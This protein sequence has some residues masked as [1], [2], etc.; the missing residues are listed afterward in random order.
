MSSP[1][2][3]EP[4]ASAP[5]SKSERAYRW[6]RDRIDHHRYGPGYRLVLGAI[7]DELQM[8]VV[9]V[10]EA[11]RRLEAE[12]LVTFERNVGARVAVVD[13]QEYVDTMQTLGIVEGTATAM[14]A[15]LLSPGDLRQADLINRQMH[16]LLKSFDAQAFTALNQQFHSILFA[17]CPNKQLL[18][19][20][21][22]GWVR[23][24]GLRDSSFS[25]IPGRAEHSVAEHADLVEMIRAGADP[26]DIELAAREHRWRTLNAFLDARH[27]ATTNTANTANTASPNT[28]STNATTRGRKNP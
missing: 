22:R 1:A 18:D 16:R 10:R 17:P 25:V 5:A 28:A 21:D 3:S 24:S 19:L 12:G 6:I 4:P 7:A 23:L 13:E 2:F 27:S 20:V 8:S 26:L 9:P 15:P 14:A 11:I